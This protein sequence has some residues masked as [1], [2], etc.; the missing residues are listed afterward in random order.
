MVTGLAMW[1]TWS[2]YVGVPKIIDLI[3]MVMGLYGIGGIFEAGRDIA[4]S[5]G[6]LKK[7]VKVNSKERESRQTNRIREGIT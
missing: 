2:I 5:I 3:E 7:V 1:E 4:I 6:S